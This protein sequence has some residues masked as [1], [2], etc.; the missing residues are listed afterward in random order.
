M[1]TLIICLKGHK[2]L[3]SLFDIKK[4]KVLVCS[5][6]VTGVGEELSQTLVWTAKN[7]QELSYG[8]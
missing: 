4:L 2:S 3:G 8:F 5:Q 1:I 6:V 7:R